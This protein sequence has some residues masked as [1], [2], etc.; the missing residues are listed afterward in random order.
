MKTFK[1]VEVVYRT[2]ILKNEGK[3]FYTQ[4]LPLDGDLG[5][6]LPKLKVTRRRLQK[7]CPSG[8]FEATVEQFMTG[9]EHCKSGMWLILNCDGTMIDRDP[10]DHLPIK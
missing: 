5:Q 8:R 2:L 10:S 7:L 1:N 3:K 9:F 6:F 4:H